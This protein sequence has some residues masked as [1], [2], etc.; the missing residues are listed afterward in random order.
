MKRTSV[1]LFFFLLLSARFLSAQSLINIIPKPQNLQESKG[2]FIISPATVI[3]VKDNL[4]IQADQLKHYLEPA[5]GFDLAIA[6]KAVQNNVIEIRLD[7]TLSKLGEEGYQ[8]NIEPQ[9]I[10]LIALNEKGIVWGIQTLRQLLPD[11]ILRQAT[12]KGM[13]W[14]IPC[15]KIED[16][17]RFKWRGLMLDCSRTFIAKEQ[18][19][20]YLEQMSLYKMN[21]LHMHLTDDQGWRLEI[22]KYPELTSVCSKFDTA[23]HEPKEYEGFYSQD[24]IRE[25]IAF[26]AQRNIEI[27]PEIEMPGHTSELFAAFPQLSCKGDTLKVRPWAKGAGVHNDVFCAGN[28]ATFDFL[29]NVLDEA[30]AL[31]PSV[32]FHIGGD[33]APKKF[34]KECPKCQKRIKDEGLKDENELQSWFVKRI[35]KYLNSKGKKLTGWDEIMDGGL[36]ETATVMYWRSWQ[37]DVAKKIPTISNAIIMSP[38]SHSYFDYTYKNISTE[39]V[40]SFDPASKEVFGDHVNNVLGVQAN[41]WSH[42][43]RTPPRIDRQLFP[44]IL[45]MAEIAWTDN[46][47]KDWKDFNTRLQSKLRSLDVMGIYYYNENQ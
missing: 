46:A 42:L 34:W 37:K 36:S 23:F 9:K 10:T 15:L 13:E 39:K 2:S 44:R 5:L 7:K 31:F 45:A 32:Y 16:Q 40:Y 26:A 8:L 47:R 3:V 35:E 4:L 20:K 43:D 28:E 6:A 25:L 17:P 11:Q 29:K 18:I 21:V 19:K 38:T 30:T 22:K 14:K 27:V 41:F 24:D 12:V 33:E 1:Y